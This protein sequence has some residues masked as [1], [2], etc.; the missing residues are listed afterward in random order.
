MFSIQ[1]LLT[2]FDPGVAECA[3]GAGQEVWEAMIYN[4]C[5]KVWG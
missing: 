4:K 1:E 5:G 2:N 3:A